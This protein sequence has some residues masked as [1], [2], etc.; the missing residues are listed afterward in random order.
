MVR[1]VSLCMAFLVVASP[2]F[3]SDGALEID[4]TCAVSTG[5]F[6]GD[7]PGFPVTITRTE[8]SY[9]LT[10]S[11]VVPNA[12][13]TA[14]DVIPN[15]ANDTIDL[16][17]FTIRGVTSCSGIPTSS[18]GPVGTGIG[19][20]GQGAVRVRNGF[21]TN[22]GS[23]G[24]NLAFSSEVENLRARLNGGDGIHGGEGASVRGCEGNSNGGD[25]IDLG[26]EGLVR[27]SV[28]N[29]NQGF[30]ILMLG[31]ALS[32][33]VSSRNGSGS[34]SLNALAG[35]GAHATGGN[36]CDDGRCSARGARRYYLT[37][38]FAPGGG[39]LGACAR[40]FH[41]GSMWELVDA[42]DLE[43]DTALGALQ[44]DSG[45][46]A[47]IL[48]GLTSGGGWIRT[49]AP[50]SGG[51]LA[52]GTNCRAWSSNGSADFG[53]MATPNPDWNSTSSIGVVNPWISIA[54]SCN[55]P[56]R[57]WCVED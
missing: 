48:V 42:S 55:A 27:D 33:N 25:G 21:I 2:A 52:G 14:I 56:Q 12:N 35:R 51:G 5:C 47:P 46:S 37:Q 9:R 11:L 22:M 13:T 28:A 24:V 26:I 54:V 45:S 34:V 31:G 1:L 29:G 40:G 16:G 41:M 32:D 36:V 23:D 4:Q 53:T 39:A 10:S 6:P 30:G 38:T 3:A 7:A 57:V 43:Y 20:R 49:G 44:D 17:G 19:V 15:D 18:C 50:S 8:A